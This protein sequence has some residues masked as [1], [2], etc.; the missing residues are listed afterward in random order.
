MM[1]R[2]RQE[3]ALG[4]TL[5]VKSGILLALIAVL[6][7]V[8][9][10]L[11]ADPHLGQLYGVAQIASLCI[12]ATGAFCAVWSL[13]PRDYSLP[14]APEAYR[15]FFEGVGLAFPDDPDGGEH[16]AIEGIASLAA[17]RI[18][19]NHALNAT[20]SKWLNFAFFPAIIALTINLITLV[21]LAASK[22]LF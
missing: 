3:L 5:D 21:C 2:D 10:T 15:R 8:S 18:E 16:Y 9:G 19:V 1:E 6:A 22:T 4:D 12:A 13:F 17:Q 7:T 14:G 20:K 11:L